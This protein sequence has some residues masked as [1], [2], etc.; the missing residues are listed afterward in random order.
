MTAP[1]IR[2]TRVLTGRARKDLNKGTCEDLIYATTIKIDK[3]VK[4]K[5][6]KLGAIELRISNEQMCKVIANLGLQ[7]TLLT[8]S[9]SG[10]CQYCVLWHIQI[11]QDLGPKLMFVN[12]IQIKSNRFSVG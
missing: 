9:Y 7:S 10:R 3:A 12:T 4:E 8:T 5:K 1:K 6:R 2:E 11:T